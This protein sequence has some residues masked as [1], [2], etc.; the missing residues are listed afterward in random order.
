M[1][2][3]L[4]I[5]SMAWAGFAFS[6]TVLNPDISATLA[7][8]L[9]S[10]EQ[11]RDVLV[12]R[13]ADALESQVPESAPIPRQTVEEVAE[14]LLADEAAAT[15]IEE[16]LIEAHQRALSGDDSAVVA[17]TVD[18]NAAGR[19]ALVEARPEL[20]SLLPANP[21]VPVVVP[22][23]GLTWLGGIKA[24][25]DRY[26]L[27][28]AA[29]AAAGVI[30]AFAVTTDR[31][32]VLGRTA[33]WAFGTA[34]FWLF[35]GFGVPVLVGYALPSSFAVL[36]AMASIVSVGM[37]GPASALAAFGVGL[38]A[39]SYVFPALDRRRGA[40]M[41]SPR[42]TAPRNEAGIAST[43]PTSPPLVE[44]GADLIPGRPLGS[45]EVSARPVLTKPSSIQP[46][47]HATVEVPVV[48]PVDDEE[49]Q[50]PF[51]PRW[52]EGYGYLDDARVA[53][54]FRAQ[55]EQSHD[56]EFAGLWPTAWQLSD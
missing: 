34:A 46:D 3:S 42:K 32:G 30:L 51:G 54:F 12:S 36:G 27:I 48:G 15:A 24:G 22:G 14:R 47:L 33:I 13:T 55:P 9:L 39:L 10:N 19:T 56:D 38:L 8:R 45:G 25:L 26:V 29:V 52:L 11:L 53:P 50:S 28:G 35:V 31:A 5:G 41:M 43:V 17:N 18:L 7:R 37:K 2:L 20:E 1:G 16:A 40:T 49:Q 21:A 23:S 6:S 4:T 44:P